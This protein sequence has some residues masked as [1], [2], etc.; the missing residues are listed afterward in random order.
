MRT[1]VTLSAL[2]IIGILTLAG[3]APAL[4]V[5]GWD[6]ERITEVAAQFELA[7]DKLYKS[8]RLE[9]WE[10]M[11]RKN[12][13]YLIVQ[14][15]KTL[16]RHSTRL[17]AQLRDGQGRDETI[18]L[19]ERIERVVRDIRAKRGMAPI[20]QGKQSEIDA[21]RGKLEE[22]AAFYGK[23]LPPVAAPPTKK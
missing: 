7:V 4:D 8:A 9:T 12:V 20:L 23:T 17:A 2:T 5:E 13:I 10:P 11:Q 6:Q 1:R 3:T 14:D 16:K 15:L 22:L 19:F 21:T 18:L